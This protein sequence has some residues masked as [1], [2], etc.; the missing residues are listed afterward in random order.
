M[1]GSF[2]EESYRKESAREESLY[3]NTRD[4]RLCLVD[5]KKSLKQKNLWF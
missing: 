1:E 5:L 4:G 3:R 2:S